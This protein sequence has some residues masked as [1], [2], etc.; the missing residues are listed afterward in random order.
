MYQNG[1][2]L[3]ISRLPA[4]AIYAI[5]YLLN[6]PA[7]VSADRRRGRIQG[8]GWASL[9]G[10]RIF[11]SRFVLAA[12]REVV[13][14]FAVELGVRIRRLRKKIKEKGKLSSNNTSNYHY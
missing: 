5:S 8:T 9:I 3:D 2:N 4:L 6:R 13:W 11:Q 10:N 7:L 1:D 14:S 12:K